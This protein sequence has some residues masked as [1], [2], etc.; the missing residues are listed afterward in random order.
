MVVWRCQACGV[1]SRL[2][3]SNYSEAKKA[4]LAVFVVW[5]VGLLYGGYIMILHGDVG[6]WVFGGGGECALKASFVLEVLCV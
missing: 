6:G 5:V 4:A 1:V 2:C 3:C